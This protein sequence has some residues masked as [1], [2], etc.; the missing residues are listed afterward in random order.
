L[1]D[2]VRIGRMLSGLGFQRAIT[3]PHY[4]GLAF[5]GGGRRLKVL[6][7][8]H[9][10]TV[11]FQPSRPGIFR[12][13]AVTR[14]VTSTAPIDVELTGATGTYDELARVEAEWKEGIS[15]EV[16]ARP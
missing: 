11:K 7:A 10:T 8:P 2:M 16:L 6:F 9:P 12:D 14:L 3:D 13:P 5:G 15:V 1:A 4:T